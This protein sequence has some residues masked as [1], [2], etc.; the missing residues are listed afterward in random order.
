MTVYN[1]VNNTFVHVPQSQAFLSS[2]SSLS[3]LL[4]TTQVSVAGN[5]KQCTEGGVHWEG[6][7]RSNVNDCI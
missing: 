6:V 7:N 3:R 4:L 1:I 2:P 5:G